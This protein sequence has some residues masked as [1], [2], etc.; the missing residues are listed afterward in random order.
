MES[1][2]D[3]NPP[4]QREGDI[5][6]ES[7]RAVLIDS[8]INGLDVPKI[9]LETETSRRRGPKGLSYQYAV[10][11]GKQRL[12]AILAFLSDQLMLADDFRYFEDDTVAAAGLTLS[13]LEITYPLL[14]RQFLEFE[15]PIVRV[16]SDS[17]DLIEEMFQRLNASASLNAAERRNSVGGPTRDSV[18][19][20]AEHPLLVSCS[21]IRSARYKYRELSAKFLAIEDQLAT[22]FKISDTKASTLYRLFVDTRGTSPRIDASAMKA[23]E[24]LAKATLDRMVDV[25]DSDDRLL[26]SIG[27]VV[28]YY[29]AFRDQA[30][31]DVVDRDV[32]SEFE[33]LRREAAQ[34]SEDDPS[35]S[36]APNVRLREY[37]GLV[38]STNDG[39]ALSRRAEILKRYVDGYT[40]DEPLSGLQSIPD[41]DLPEQDDDEQP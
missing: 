29:I 22:R 37:N 18:N 4:Y 9:Y 41:G 16:T 8:I 36:A 27:T 15:L 19:A 32:L 30:F 33:S 40:S 14:A 6:K 34:M 10:I 3:L 12:G 28:V 38:Q 17:G 24:E 20:L 11:D 2:I 21:P 39:R 25:F 7:T 31:A 35:Y 26:A 13:E 1:V 5:W 23:Y